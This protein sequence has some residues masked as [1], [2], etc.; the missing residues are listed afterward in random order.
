V[1]GGLDAADINEVQELVSEYLDAR[2]LPRRTLVVHQFVP[3]MIR[4]KEELST[5][6]GVDLLI[7]TDGFGTRAQK[8]ANY[9]RYI[10]AEG[11]PHAGF[12]LFFTQDYGLMTPADVSSLVPQPRSCDLPVRST[13][14]PAESPSWPAHALALQPDEGLGRRQGLFCRGAAFLAPMPPVHSI[15]PPA[16]RPPG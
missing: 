16:F 6:P 13:A 3:G 14:S 2:G 5:Y 4:N 15:A 8:V 1:I 7:D 9:D 10:A 12:K 11:A